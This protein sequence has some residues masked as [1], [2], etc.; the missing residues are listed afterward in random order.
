VRAGSAKRNRRRTSKVN[1]RRVALIIVVAAVL[2]LLLAAVIAGLVIGRVA[3]DLTDRE[4][5]L[6]RTEQ[7]TSMDELRDRY[8]L[9][10]GALELNLE[11]LELPEGTTE[12]EARVDDGVLT[13]VV[14]Q[15]ASVRVDA[16]AENGALGIL[17]RDSS[18]EDVE[19]NYTQ[20]GYEQAQRRLSLE[21]S[22]DTGAISVRRGQ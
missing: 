16:E 5:G 21:L 9:D 2:L 18:G 10:A 3:Q 17:G 12:V 20:E 7:P 14:P 1:Q 22:V 6:V 11:D 4:D 15:D 19:R 13:V 8:E